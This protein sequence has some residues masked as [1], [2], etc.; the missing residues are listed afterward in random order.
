M[1]HLFI[2]FILVAPMNNLYK[3]TRFDFPMPYKLFKY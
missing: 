3:Q 2:S 1:K